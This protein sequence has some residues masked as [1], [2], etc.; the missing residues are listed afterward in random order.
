MKLGICT[1]AFAALCAASTSTQAGPLVDSGALDAAFGTSGKVQIAE[2]ASGQAGSN[3]VASDVAVQSNGK[4]I[5]AGYD[6]AHDCVLVRLNV[7]GSVDTGFGG[8]NNYPPGFAGYGGCSFAGVA[9]RPDDRIV[10]LDNLPNGAAAVSQFTANG[11][12]DYA[13]FGTN[14][15]AFI[16]PATGDSV[17]V[18]RIVIQNDGTLDIAGTYHQESTNNNQFLFVQISADGNTIQPLFQY[19]FGSGDNQDDHA[20]DV[21]IDTQ[22]RYVLCGYHR[23]ANGNYDFAAIRILQNLYDVDQTFGSGGQTTVA[24]DL[25][26]DNGDFCNAITI[27][28]A[29]GYMVLGGHAT[30]T[31]SNGTYQAAA[32]A[33]LDNNGNLFQYF[34][35]GL[36]YPA[37]FTFSYS[38]LPNAGQTN[39]ITRLI[40]DGYDTKYPEV[41]AIGTGNQY[42]TPPGIYLGIARF[43]PAAAMCYCNF[44]LDADLNGKGVEGVYFAERPTGFGSFTTTNYGLSGTFVNG[45]VTAAG[46]TLAPGGNQMAVTRLAAFD[47]IYKNGFETVSY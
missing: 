10:T 26:G 8:T 47:G 36:S 37:Q 12:P 17:N 15:T 11:L 22:G 16:T 6:D 9:V 25:G 32:L 21:A 28:P 13:T 29:S 46:Y 4:T 5:V 34:S 33:E 38:T 39:D 3:I 7:D 18:S 19:E 20:L 14:A 23:G 27:F 31:A 2:A 43:R 41:L 40:I 45:K 1:I 42:A 35:S 24:F 44:T 30:A